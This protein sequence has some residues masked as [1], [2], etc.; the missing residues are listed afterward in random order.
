MIYSK[1]LLFKV[2]DDVIT[3][4]PEDITCC[5]ADSK[6]TIICLSGN[7][8]VHINKPITDV[9]KKLPNR[10][11]TRV[12]RK[13]VVNV[14]YIDKVFWEFSFLTLLDGVKI[15]LYPMMKVRLENLLRQNPIFCREMEWMD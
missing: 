15:P 11:F 5:M 9:M 10:H 6:W 7:R 13:W 1:R 8:E 4:A 2:Y 3:I 14:H 12:H